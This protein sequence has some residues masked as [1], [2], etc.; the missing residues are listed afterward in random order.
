MNRIYEAAILALGL[1]VL[2]W[3]VKSGIDNFSNKDRKVSVKG[4]SELEV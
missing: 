2:G 3:F 1:V 4:L